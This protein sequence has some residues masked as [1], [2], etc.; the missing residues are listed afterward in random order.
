M[1]WDSAR[2]QRGHEAATELILKCRDVDELTLDRTEEIVRAAY[3]DLS[4][5]DAV[6]EYE[7]G[8][9][10]AASWYDIDLTA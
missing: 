10:E 7:V 4:D 5:S 1:S 6:S 9:R 8:F 2:F 3:A